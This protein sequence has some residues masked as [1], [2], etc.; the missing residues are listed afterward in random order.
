MQSKWVR[1]TGISLYTHTHTYTYIDRHIQHTHTHTHLHT[2]IYTHM[3][4][5]HTYICTNDHFDKKNKVKKENFFELMRAFVVKMLSQLKV[6]KEKIN[7][8]QFARIPTISNY[9]CNFLFCR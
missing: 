5:I 4:I 9:L 7:T 2:Y 8:R 6:G 3:H 1:H